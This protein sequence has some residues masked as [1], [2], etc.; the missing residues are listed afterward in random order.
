MSDR[1]PTFRELPSMLWANPWARTLV[2]VFVLAELYNVAVVPAVLNTF[3]G[4]ET[5]AVAA[6]A[7]TKQRGEAD[8]ATQKAS[9]EQ[10]AARNAERFRQAEAKAKSAEADLLAQKARVETEIARHAARRQAAEA[11]SKTALARKTEAEAIT[12]REVALNSGLRASSD[13]DLQRAEADL[14]QQLSIIETEVAKQAARRQLAETVLAEEQARYD[15]IIAS[16]MRGR[17]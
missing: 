10:E 2:I 13:A 15:R 5:R 1:L 8:L 17:R 4:I 9:I 16:I 14:K 11:R 3:K 6:N 12:A 7:E